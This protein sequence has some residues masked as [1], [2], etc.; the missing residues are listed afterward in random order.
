MLFR[1]ALVGLLKPLLFFSGTLWL[2]QFC[3]S[4]FAYLHLPWVYYRSIQISKT[5]H[6]NSFCGCHNNNSITMLCYTHCALNLSQ[7]TNQDYLL[8]SLQ[9]LSWERYY[10]VLQM[11]KRLI[12]VEAWAYSRTQRKWRIR[13]WIPQNS[14]LLLGATIL[15]CLFISAYKKTPKMWLNE[16]SSHRCIVLKER[17]Q[18]WRN[19]FGILF[20]LGS[21]IDTLQHKIS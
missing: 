6:I 19:W 15:L 13:I 16:G 18:N 2:G 20:G 17:R 21:K 1:I 5:C 9:W 14:K 4:G 11:K 8:Q 3:S 7:V 12:E 10:P